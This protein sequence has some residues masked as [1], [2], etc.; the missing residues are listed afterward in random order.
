MLYWNPSPRGAG[1]N[2]LLFSL[3]LGGRTAVSLTGGPLSLCSPYWARITLFSLISN[4]SV[5]TRIGSLLA[6][7]L[8]RNNGLAPHPLPTP[9]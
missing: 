5:A 9:R 6:S 1:L 3:S 4:T 8:S 2:P 7:P